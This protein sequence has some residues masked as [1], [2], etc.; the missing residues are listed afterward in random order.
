MAETP[1][2]KILNA[3]QLELENENFLFG[4]GVS[5]GE[6]GALHGPSIMP[7]GSR[8][9][10]DALEEIFTAAAAK[11]DDGEPCVDY[12]GPRG[13][14]IMSKWSIMGSNMPLCS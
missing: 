10:W 12:I 13:Q 5:G 14:A 7:G 6:E 9:A 2:L 8:A 3:A 1:F 4:A 11:A